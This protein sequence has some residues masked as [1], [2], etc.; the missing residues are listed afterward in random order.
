MQGSPR[1]ALR[2]VERAGMMTS[3]SHS[4][5]NEVLARIAGTRRGARWG[6]THS[7][8]KLSRQPYSDVVSMLGFFEARKLSLL[9]IS[10]FHCR[11]P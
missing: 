9:S 11:Y 7:L 5:H 6:I 8:L 1:R 4:L 3:Q 10:G 2:G